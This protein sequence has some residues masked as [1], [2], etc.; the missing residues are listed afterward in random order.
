MSIFLV[1]SNIKHN[2]E[3][4]VKGSLFEGQ[5][6]HL[7]DL[8]QDGAIVLVGD[9]E[10]FEEANKILSQPAKEEEE[11]NEPVP[12]NTWGPQPDE[13]APVQT[14]SVVETN[15]DVIDEEEK[16]D[17]VSVDDSVVSPSDSDTVEK[18]DDTPVSPD[19]EPDNL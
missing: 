1:K 17:S 19:E 7:Q 3:F 13:V 8:I 16:T 14:D 11:I 18:T 2:G 6:G 9:A 15:T 5:S 10:T 4:F 12:Q